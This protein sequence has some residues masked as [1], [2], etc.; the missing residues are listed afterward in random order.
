MGIIPKFVGD[1]FLSFLVGI[2]IDVDIVSVHIKSL[3]NLGKKHCLIPLIS[4]IILAKI[5]RKIGVHG[6]IL[7]ITTH[8]T[9]KMRD[10]I[11]LHINIIWRNIYIKHVQ[12]SVPRS[13]IHII[14]IRSFSWFLVQIL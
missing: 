4:E 3:G 6:S 10:I 14:C 1:R 12:A 8:C 9:Y 13:L 2:I 7:I 11:F 5:I